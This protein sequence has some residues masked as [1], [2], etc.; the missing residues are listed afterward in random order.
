MVITSS[1]GPVQRYT[2]RPTP[3]FVV[4]LDIGAKATLL[5]LLALVLR[6]PAWGNLEGEGACRP[7][8][9][10]PAIGFHRA[11]R[12]GHQAADPGLS[13]ARGP[14]GDVDLLLRHTREPARPL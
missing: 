1:A 10:L 4:M 6:D 2:D 13:L 5:A 9:H 12:V 8:H 14:V 3:R 11:R 7:G